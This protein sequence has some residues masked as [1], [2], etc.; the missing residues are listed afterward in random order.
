LLICCSNRLIINNYK[1]C[2]NP[3]NKTNKHASGVRRIFVV[4]ICCF[5]GSPRVLKWFPSLPGKQITSSGHKIN[6]YVI[7]NTTL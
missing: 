2:V 5:R 1:I 4:V 6:S 7:L 3:K